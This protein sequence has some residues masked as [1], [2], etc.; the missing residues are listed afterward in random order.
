[1]TLATDGRAPV[2]QDHTTAQL[3]SCGRKPSKTSSRL[4]TVS[5]S[6]RRLAVRLAAIQSCRIQNWE[7]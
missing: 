2:S 6:I 1:M 7:R 4:S 3:S 5:I